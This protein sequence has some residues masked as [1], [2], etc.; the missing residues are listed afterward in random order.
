MDTSRTL[1]MGAM[2]RWGEVRIGVMSAVDELGAEYARLRVL[3]PAGE[4]FVR[5]LLG[6][7]TE[8]DGVG[9]VSLHAMHLHHPGLGDDPDV[10]GADSVEISF[11]AGRGG[12]AR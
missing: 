6:R 11:E 12:D 1:P 9:T 4:R 2:E 10:T 7:S 3:C 8:V 5:V